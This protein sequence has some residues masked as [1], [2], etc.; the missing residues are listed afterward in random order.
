[1]DALLDKKQAH[2]ILTLGNVPLKK[3]AKE[4]KMD[5]ARGTGELYS[6]VIH[7]SVTSHFL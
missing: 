1:M 2:L 6:F 4:R 3:A 7:Y 5:C